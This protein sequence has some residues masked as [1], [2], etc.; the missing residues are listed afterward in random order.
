MVEKL[1]AGTP[2]IEATSLP[3]YQ[4][5]YQGLGLLAHN[6]LP[7]EELII[8]RRIAEILADPLR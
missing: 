1:R 4:P 5:A 3:D 7:G 8:A 2:S 6:L